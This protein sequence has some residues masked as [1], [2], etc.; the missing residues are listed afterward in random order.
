MKID[1][2]CHCGAITYAA[3]VDPADVGIC[4]CTDCQ[5]LAGT[6]FRT[7]VYTPEANFT[8]L[9]G[10]PKTYVKTA[11]SGNRRA[12]VFCPACGTPIYAT[13]VGA[14]PKVFGLRVGAIRQRDD[15]PPRKQCWTRSAQTWLGTIGFL[16]KIERQ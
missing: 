10:Q 8:L 11:E 2:G 4:H 12:Q 3:E 1:G 16:P 5:T 14:G 15:L 9:S 6:A 7:T 13:S